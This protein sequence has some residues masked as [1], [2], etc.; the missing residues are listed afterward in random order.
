MKKRISNILG[1]SVMLLYLCSACSTE[2]TLDTEKSIEIGNNVKIGSNAVVKH[3]VPDDAIVYE[4]RPSVKNPI[5]QRSLLRE[6][7]QCGIKRL[8]WE[9][10]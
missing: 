9:T 5:L 1:S 8:I 4:P 2:S 7:Q 3:S 10:I 6:L